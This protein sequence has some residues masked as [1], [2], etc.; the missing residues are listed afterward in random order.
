MVEAIAAGCVPFS[1]PDV[2]A[3]DVLEVSGIGLVYNNAADAVA[4]V[5]K[6]LEQEFSDEEVLKISDTSKRLS[7][8]AFRQWIRGV[9]QSA[10]SSSPGASSLICTD[11]AAQPCWDSRV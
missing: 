7:P 3:T 9:L 10:Q 2:G 4:K 8:E 5:Q 1:P 11:K 6:V